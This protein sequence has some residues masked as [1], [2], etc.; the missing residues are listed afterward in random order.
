[1]FMAV[2]LDDNGGDRGGGDCG[3]GDRILLVCGGPW[4][5]SHS[6]PIGPPVAL[7]S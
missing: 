4:P 2:I 3:D 5:L 6:S 7:M 1:M